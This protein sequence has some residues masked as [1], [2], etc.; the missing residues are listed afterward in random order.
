MVVDALLMYLYTGDYSDKAVTQD[1]KSSLV[2]IVQV[3]SLAEKFMA[4]SLV[5]FAAKKFRH[6]LQEDWDEHTFADAI[7]EWSRTTMD[8]KKI[9]G[10]I[11][12]NTIISRRLELF[13]PGKRSSRV[14]EVLNQTPWLSGEIARMLTLNMEDNAGTMVYR[15]PNPLCGGMFQANMIPGTK[16]KLSCHWCHRV[17]D[18]KWSTWRKHVVQVPVVK[19]NDDDH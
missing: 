15:C 18:M 11:I 17:S 4:P 3:F 16:F 10:D 13:P 6:V 5:D 2:F 9:L 19:N 1:G 12:V 8:P 14:R 7:D